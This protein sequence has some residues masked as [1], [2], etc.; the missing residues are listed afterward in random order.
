[1]KRII[2]EELLSNIATYM[3][4]NIREWCHD[5]YMGK[6]PE[7]FLKGYYLRLAYE[8]GPEAI[9]N[10]CEILRNEFDI[11]IYDYVSYEEEDEALGMYE[12][13]NEYGTFCKN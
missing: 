5:V 4:D 1:M 12:D 3:D 7:E 11:N 2:S 13:T 9:D 10:F 8:Q 6:E